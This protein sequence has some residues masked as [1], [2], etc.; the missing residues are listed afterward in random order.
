MN[1]GA[2]SAQ[3]MTTW[4]RPFSASLAC[5]LH[6]RETQSRVYP[7]VANVLDRRVKP[8]HGY[9]AVHLIV[10]ESNK[11]IE[12]QVRT[13]LQHEWAEMSE[14]CADMIDQAIKYGGGPP[15]VRGILDRA[16]QQVHRIEDAESA[17]LHAGVADTM[18][19]RE[20]HEIRNEY[21]AIL[22]SLL[23]DL[24]ESDWGAS[25]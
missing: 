8:S 24:S 5:L 19:A 20:L 9:R 1:T 11:P 16:A 2:L 3:P 25:S 15:P 23:K 21:V 6:R 7:F 17:L 14:K 22:Q 12:V 10:R 4:S 13:A 18:L